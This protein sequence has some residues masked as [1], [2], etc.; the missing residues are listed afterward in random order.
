VHPARSLGRGEGLGIACDKHQ[1]R[2]DL[3]QDG[4][5][6]LHQLT[7]DLALTSR[8]TAVT[9]AD[10][11]DCQQRAISAVSIGF[12][13][14]GCRRASELHNGLDKPASG[15]PVIAADIGQP[16][17]R[18]HEIWVIGRGSGGK[19]PSYSRVTVAPSRRGAGFDVLTVIDGRPQTRVILEPQTTDMH[20]TGGRQ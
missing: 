1:I 14:V 12:S 4:I 20:I 9:G 10:Q 3:L 11:R 8:A 13:G 5:E 6:L 7:C 15:R 16:D 19:E 2:I 17:R 18:Q